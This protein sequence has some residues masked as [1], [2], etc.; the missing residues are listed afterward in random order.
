MG[1]K[2]DSLGNLYMGLEANEIYLLSLALPFLS[3]MIWGKLL[4]F[5]FS[6]KLVVCKREMGDD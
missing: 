4:S 2:N 5:F 6:F 3:Y 1:Q